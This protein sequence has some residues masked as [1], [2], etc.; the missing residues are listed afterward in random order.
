MGMLLFGVYKGADKVCILMIVLFHNFFMK[1]YVVGT[2]YNHL[3]D[4]ILICNHSN[5]FYEEISKEFMIDF[6]VCHSYWVIGLQKIHW[7][8]QERKTTDHNLL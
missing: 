1:S 3:F 2:H 5:R 7:T 6:I 4:K 8:Q